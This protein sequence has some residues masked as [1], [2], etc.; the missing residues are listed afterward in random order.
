[1]NRWHLLAIVLAVGVINFGISF[2]NGV[3][4]DLT[5]LL[6]SSLVA[7][8]LG[9]FLLLF[10][11]WLWRIPFLYPWFVQVP[12]IRGDWE[13][14]GDINWIEPNQTQKIPGQLSFKQT[15]FSIWAK[16]EWEDG[17]QMN[18]LMKAPIAARAEGFCAFTAIYEIDPKKSGKSP[19]TRRAGFFFHTVEQFPND[20]AIFYSTTDSQS[21]ILR[22]SNRK[23]MSAWRRLMPN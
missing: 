18:F 20:L 7:A 4:F 14:S 6:N 1:M 12:C 2:W 23:K 3:P 22:L 17:A 16:I 15:Y 9:G 13:I 11:W 19:N 21:G 8:F 5:S 10:D